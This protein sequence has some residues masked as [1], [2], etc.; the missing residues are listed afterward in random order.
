MLNK[1]PVYSVLVS[2]QDDGGGEWVDPEFRGLFGKQKDAEAYGIRWSMN[3]K[4]F[5]AGVY[6]CILVSEVRASVQSEIITD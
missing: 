6:E 1:I 4:G 2:M 3:H 5:T